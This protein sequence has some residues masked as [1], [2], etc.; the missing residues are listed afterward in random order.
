MKKSILAKILLTIAAV[1]ILT[2][3]CL[4][5]LGFSSVYITV[6]RTYLSYA[7]SSAAVAADLL[8]GVDMDRLQAEEKFTEYYRDILEELCRKNDLEYLYVYVPDP[9]E[10]TI[11]FVMLICGENSSPLAAAERAPGTEIAH[12]LNA[13][14]SSVWNGMETEDVEETDNQYGHVM[15]AYS[16]VYDGKGNTAALVG[17][18]VSMDEAFHI[19][20]RRYRIMLAAVVLSFVFVLGVL[21]AILKTRVLKPAEI[22]SKRMKNFVTDRQFGFKKIE[23]KGSDEFAQ[24]AGAFNSM[25]EEMD[26]YIQNINQLTEEKHR[27]EAEIQIAKNIQSGF[28]PAKSFQNSRIRLAATMIPAKYVGGDFYDYFS[29]PDGGICTVIADVS[30]KGISAALFMARAITVVRQYAQLGYSPAKILFHTNNTLASHNPEQMFLTVFVGIYCGDTHQ[31]VYANGGHNTPYLL[32]DRV[33]KIEGA[34]GMAIGIFED[35]TYEEGEILLQEGDTVFLYTDGVNEAVSSKRE[36]FGTDRLEHILE[37]KGREKCVDAVLEAVREFAQGAQPSDDITMLAFCVLP[38]AC[39]TGI[40]VKAELA[41]LEEVQNLI[42][43]NTGIPDNLKK[44]LCLAAEETFVNI[45]SYAY[46]KGPGKVEISLDVSENIV[47]KFSDTGKP[48]NPL[49]NQIEIEDYDPEEQIGGLGRWIAFR[50]ADNVEY[51]YKHNK[52]ILTM[53]MEYKEEQK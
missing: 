20:F 1:L 45:C 23:V 7:R 16:A 11:R 22:V 5:A 42:L 37:Q 17:A 26:Q 49:E 13:S 43:Q 3:L 21:A 50:I 46:E 32:S 10:K 2:D 33:Q 40:I 47:L 18:D 51:E 44:R 9:K 29:L 35:E 25:A 31:F 34:K 30:G 53:M 15:T 41:S 12:E 39:S 38:D 24:M 6:H 28:L 14:E 4:L 19:F 52:N 48:F 36:F 8:D 27:Q